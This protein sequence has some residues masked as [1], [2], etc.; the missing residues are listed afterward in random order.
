[1]TRIDAIGNPLSAIAMLAL[2]FCAVPGHAQETR[3]LKQ[4]KSAG[5]DASLTVLPVRLGDRLFP[6]VGEVVGMF[7]ERGGM[8]NLEIGSEEFRPPEKA[9]LAETGKA[10][11][12]FVKA[13]PSKT[14]YTLF[15]DFLVSPEH[16][17]VEVRGVIVDQEGGIVWQDHQTGDD[18][19]FKRIGPKEPM[20]CCILL[21]ERLRPVLGLDDP[22]RA[23]ANESKLAER[24]QKKTGVAD[25]AEK[26]AMEKREQ[27]FKK[28]AAEATLLIYPARAGDEMSKAS[29]TYLA[30]L[31]NQAKLAKATAADV[32]PPIKVRREM[33]EQKT[34]WDM[35]RAFREQVQKQPPDA[36]YVLF[37]DY[38][39]GKNAV[40]AVHF[41]ICDRHGELVVVDFQN[42]HH[43][44]FN[45]IKP[46]SR[47]DCDRLVVKR[48]K[49]YCR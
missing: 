39:I 1:M 35:A 38:L 44:D 17:F 30:E 2:A 16:Q 43:D 20:Q 26:A 22:M 11:G 49:K 8:K 21:V 34:L 12:E 40:G 14:A 45:A 4:F 28:A 6:Q 19:D 47:E 18:A 48:L 31:V 24:W 25:K 23:G 7:L 36:D 37:A 10:L 41:A 15:A 29:A 42:N 27:A 3:L 13:H 5:R 32:G 33:N 46:K 9:T